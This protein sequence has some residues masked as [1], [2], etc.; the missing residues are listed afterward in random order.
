MLRHMQTHH[1]DAYVAKK[2][3]QE[4][5]VSKALLAD[6]WKEYHHPENFPPIR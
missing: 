5:R 3:V 4:E 2:K 1:S 6:G